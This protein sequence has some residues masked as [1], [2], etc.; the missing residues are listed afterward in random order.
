VSGTEIGPETFDAVRGALEQL[1]SD[2]RTPLDGG[3]DD[4]A[5]F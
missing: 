4:P 1:A 3:Y 2:W 5:A